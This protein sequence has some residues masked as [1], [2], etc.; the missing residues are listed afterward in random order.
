MKKIIT[1]LI[2]TAIL[3]VFNNG[4]KKGSDNPIAPTPTENYFP[5]SEGTNYKYSYQR[6]DSSGQ[7]DGIRTTYYKGSKTIQGTAYKIQI[8]S[9][10]TST[11]V[12]VDSSYFRI[13]T[14]GVYYFLDT[15]GLAA[16]IE[17][18]TLIQF[19]PFILVD[20]ELLAYATPL[21]VGG[22]WTSFKMNLN[23]PGLP[24]TTLVDL[25]AE[26]V[27]KESISLNLS[28]GSVNKEAIKIKFTLKL[29]T[30][31]LSVVTQS[32]SADAWLVKDIG[33]AKWDGS[34]TIVN[35]FTG[36]G[37][38]FADTTVVVRQSLIDYQIK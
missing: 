31:P 2:V 14:A 23:L 1:L 16:S 5:S 24:V 25:Y 8:D 27:G 10:F 35:F 37:I 12:G 6:I 28:S 20:K 33:P 30:N 32:F 19:L 34:G 21:Q 38:D 11:L 7:I 22:K 17:D 4:C 13:A 36:L 15:T 9:L 26:A 3:I 29:R 18:S